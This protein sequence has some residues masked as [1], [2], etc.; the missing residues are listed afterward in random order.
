M[1]HPAT[2]IEPELPA[3]AND[4]V[5][6]AA[7]RAPV[8]E[9][10]TEEEEQLAAEAMRSLH[11]EVAAFLALDETAMNEGVA[12]FAAEFEALP[13]SERH[14]IDEIGRGSRQRAAL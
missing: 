10:E 2:K 4:P 1:G 13:E 6:Q 12:R 9:P 11:P 5:W 3:L 7:L 8:G 14:M